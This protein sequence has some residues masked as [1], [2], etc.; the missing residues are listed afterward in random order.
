MV[1]SVGE[2]IWKDTYGFDF[3]S[4][5]PGDGANA[6]PTM[7]YKNC[8]KA[9]FSKFAEKCRKKGGVFKCCSSG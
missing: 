3:V 8:L 6:D 7:G 2:Q 9:D 1:T 4:R 5:S